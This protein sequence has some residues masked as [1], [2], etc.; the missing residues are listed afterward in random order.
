MVLDLPE[1]LKQRPGVL[2]RGRT[3]QQTTVHP[4]RIPAGRDGGILD[5]HGGRGLEVALRRAP[6]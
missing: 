1:C 4:I 5:V 3:V 6:T 2:Y